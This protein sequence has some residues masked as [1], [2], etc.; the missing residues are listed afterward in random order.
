M[1]LKGV[2][3]S[4]ISWIVP[5][6]CAN[7]RGF[8][9]RFHFDF[10]SSASNGGSIDIKREKGKERKTEKEKRKGGS[11]NYGETW[12]RIPGKKTAATGTRSSP[13]RSSSPRKTTGRE[14]EKERKKDREELAERREGRRRRS[15]ERNRMERPVYLDDSPACFARRPYE[16]G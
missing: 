16:T 4:A 3:F 1:N 11:T 7:F 15:V 13:F 6:F 2:Q 8:T 12:P 9:A 14:R 5:K 10:L